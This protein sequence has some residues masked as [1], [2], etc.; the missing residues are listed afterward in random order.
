MRHQSCMPG[1]CCGRSIEVHLQWVT[2]NLSNPQYILRKGPGSSHLN[3]CV[4]KVRARS[5][6][7]SM[8][9]EGAAGS[10]FAAAPGGTASRPGASRRS[11]SDEDCPTSPCWGPASA[12][13]RSNA[14][15]P[16]APGTPV[17]NQSSSIAS[18]SPLYRLSPP[19]PHM[20]ETNLQQLG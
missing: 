5:R 10:A 11:M 12:C 9:L 18:L 14:A 17:Q 19:S 16:G 8:G 4:T 2:K 15:A 1:M 3:R 6:T 13:R 7:A 20:H